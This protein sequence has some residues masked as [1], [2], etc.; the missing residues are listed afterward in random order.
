[1]WGIEPGALSGD[2]NR[3]TWLLRVSLH[4]EVHNREICWHLYRNWQRN[5]WHF[6]HCKDPTLFLFIMCV[7]GCP[8]CD[9]NDTYKVL[10]ALS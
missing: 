2:C 6:F 3:I 9:H 10:S 8:G 7:A 5:I 4:I 1:M